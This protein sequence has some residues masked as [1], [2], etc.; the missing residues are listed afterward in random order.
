MLFRND[1]VLDGVSLFAEIPQPLCEAVTPGY[2]V[3]P[4][5]L[6]L[7]N[8][9]GTE[10]FPGITEGFFQDHP[11]RPGDA[12]IQLLVIVLLAFSWAGAKVLIYAIPL[13]DFVDLVGVA[14]H[15][16]GAVLTGGD[17]MSDHF[18]HQF[19]PEFV[20]E[21]S[22]LTG[23]FGPARRGQTTTANPVVSK[24]W[25]PVSRRSASII[26]LTVDLGPLIKNQTPMSFDSLFGAFIMLSPGIPDTFPSAP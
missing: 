16:M 1:Q 19:F 13:D 17:A 9:E 23:P 26:D 12:G 25:W 3:F 11:L 18:D 8:G 10:P 21:S 15:R 6:I 4:V 5:M 14:V 7:C 24:V 20:K 22:G 2:Q